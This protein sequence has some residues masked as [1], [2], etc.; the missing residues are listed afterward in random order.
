MFPPDVEDTGTAPVAML[1][2]FGFLTVCGTANRI[3]KSTLANEDRSRYNKE[4]NLKSRQ[5]EQQIDAAEWQLEYDKSLTPVQKEILQEQIRRAKL[6]N[7]WYEADIS[8]QIANRNANTD[9][10]RVI[11]DWYG[12][13]TS[14]D[15]N[16]TNVKSSLEPAKVKSQVAVNNSTVRKKISG[17]EKGR[18][19]SG[20]HKHKPLQ[21]YSQKCCQQLQFATYNPYV[22]AYKKLFK[23]IKV[24]R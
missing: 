20:K 13:K 1:A 24:L 8:S 16:Y 21:R 14:A 15:V 23:K 18:C 2:V 17:S 10:T 3:D 9:Y 12:P 6:E 22:T 4:W 11:S 7:D 5:L 19:K